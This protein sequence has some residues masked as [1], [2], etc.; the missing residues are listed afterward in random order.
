MYLKKLCKSEALISVV[1]LTATLSLARW[2]E[3]QENR[4]K[5]CTFDSYIVNSVTVT[6]LLPETGFCDTVSG[7]L[8]IDETTN[9]T[10]QQLSDALG[11]VGLVMGNVAIVNTA[12]TNLSFF[13]ELY[14]VTG[15]VDG[16]GYGLLIMN[17][18]KLET[19]N[20][21]L[22]LTHPVAQIKGNPLLDPNCTHVYLYYPTNRDRRIRKNRLNCGCEVDDPITNANIHQIDDNCNLI[23]GDLIIHGANSPSP[24]ILA[25]K[26]ASATLITGE[27][28][29][30]NTNYTVLDFLKNVRTIE[31]HYEESYVQREEIEDR[32]CRIGNVTNVS[33]LPDDCHTLVG[34]LT[35]DEQSRPE[36]FW[37]LYNVTRIYGGLTIRNSSLKSFSP[38][39]QLNGIYSFAEDQSA[40]VIESNAVLKSAYF[41]VME[42]M[43][44]YLPC[45][46]AENPAL[47]ISE[48]ECGLL[49]TTTAD[50]VNFRG[51]KDDCP[52]KRGSAG[53][54]VEYIHIPVLLL[55][56]Y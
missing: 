18:T 49:N 11:R 8:R 40:L 21:A 55:A 53:S 46:I 17:N 45:S 31:V 28:S 38:L 15:S 14:A 3:G 2:V 4:G 9:L 29:I 7:S 27:I 12:F 13:S 47:S 39:W 35:I 20:G 44:S 19:M 25:E 48:H 1:I 30:V 50:R 43:M 26:F 54:I 37:K 10:H 22:L 32:V 52:G 42:R 51:N 36:D 5:T 16:L 6:S 56:L 23:L 41:G 34:D 33:V 24:E